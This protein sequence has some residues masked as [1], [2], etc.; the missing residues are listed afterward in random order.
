MRVLV[1]GAN[2]QVGRRLVP[3]LVDAGHEVRAMVRDEGQAADQEE[4]GA[5]PVVGDLEGEFEHALDGRDAV[6]FTAGSGGHTGAD[7]T[8]LVDGYGAVRAV[9]AARERGAGRFVMVSARGADDPGRSE[10]LKHYLVAKLIADRYL[11]ES[12]LDYTILRPGTLTDDPPTGRIRV[13]RDVGRGTITRG[14]VAAT[15]EAALRIPATVG[16]TFE[17]LN[18]GAPIDEALESL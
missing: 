5:E 7:K 3:R 2:G 13:G 12:G 1:I 10:P 16:R 11:E 6:V 14:D 18:D 17:M 15:A 8:A 4:L 9:D